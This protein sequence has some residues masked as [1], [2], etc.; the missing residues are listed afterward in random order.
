MV[1]QADEGRDGLRRQ[2][3]DSAALTAPPQPCLRD[4]VGRTEQGGAGHAA[5][6]L[7]ERDVERV[8]ERCDLRQPAA[9]PRLRFP[10]ART[11][12]VQRDT[13]GAASS[14]ELRQV[15]PGRQQAAGL[16]QRQFG[17]HGAQPAG[18]RLEVSR[19][20]GLEAAG[21]QADLQAV[22][23]ARAVFLVQ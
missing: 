21:Q 9:E 10:D 17:E 7:V 11:V 8:G 16:A 23:Q 6:P 20:G 22:Q 13:A 15:I 3:V 2:V 1:V 19:R 12:E 4:E 14:G 5:E 18:Y